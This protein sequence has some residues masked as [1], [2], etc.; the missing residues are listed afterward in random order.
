MVKQL[1]LTF[2]L[3]E[4]FPNVISD[5]EKWDTIP[6]IDIQNKIT[7]YYQITDNELGNQI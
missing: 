1:E 5:F 6:P 7:K 4:D 3:E 2:S